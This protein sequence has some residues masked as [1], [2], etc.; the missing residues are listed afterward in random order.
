MSPLQGGERK[1]SSKRATKSSIIAVDGTKQACPLVTFQFHP[2]K[3][4]RVQLVTLSL[5]EWQRVAQQIVEA[6]SALRC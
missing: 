6:G 4:G 3:V 2:P 5:C 1:V